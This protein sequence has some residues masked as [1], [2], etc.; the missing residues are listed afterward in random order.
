MNNF[1]RDD[2]LKN[3]NRIKEARD[4]LKDFLSN[5]YIQPNRGDL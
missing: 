3:E 1:V 5:G 2:L 4:E